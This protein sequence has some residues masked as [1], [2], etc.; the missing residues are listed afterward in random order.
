MAV[1]FVRSRIVT[2]IDPRLRLERELYA[3]M[4]L[5]PT[6]STGLRYAG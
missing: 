5:T 3:A 4:T 1:R 2:V 6:M